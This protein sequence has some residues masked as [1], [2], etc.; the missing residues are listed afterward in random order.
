VDRNAG[1]LASIGESFRLVQ[2]SFWS[3]L[4]FLVLGFFLNL[5][6]ALLFGLGLL[7]TI[8]VTSLSLTYLYRR[9]QRRG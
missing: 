4:G 5:L 9:L 3:V 2:G 6:G 1:A 7:V 8:P